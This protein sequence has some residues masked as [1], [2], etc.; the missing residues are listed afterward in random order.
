MSAPVAKLAFSTNTND[1]EKMKG[2]KAQPLGMELLPG[3]KIAIMYTASSQSFSN[4]S[5]KYI[6]VYDGNLNELYGTKINSFVTLFLYDSKMVYK[7]GY[8]N[9]FHLDKLNSI[10]TTVTYVSKINATGSLPCHTN[11]YIYQGG[12]VIYNVITPYVDSTLSL[13]STPAFGSASLVFAS[14][15]VPLSLNTI[16]TNNDGPIASAFSMQGGKCNND[17]MILV[18]YSSQANTYKW[19]LNNALISTAK[20]IKILPP[21]G[22]NT[23]KLEAYKNGKVDT[24]DQ[25]FY[26]SAIP[27]VKLSATLLNNGKITLADTNSVQPECMRYFDFGD[28]YKTSSYTMAVDTHSYN[29]YGVYDVSIVAS[30]GDCDSSISATTIIFNLESRLGVSSPSELFIQPNLF[31]GIFDTKL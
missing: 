11:N 6:V 30:A 22:I 1:F 28:G 24:Y 10:D 13:T 18:N 19:Y 26:T 15:N 2:G 29:H 14:T 12:Y 9:Y 7:N 5:G 16:C 21:V 20:S 25:S 27:N 31:L 17:S 8:L 4:T 3:N 23:V